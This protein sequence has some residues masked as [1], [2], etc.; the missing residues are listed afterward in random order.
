MDAPAIRDQQVHLLQQAFG[1]E[2][3]GG[4]RQM[5]DIAGIVITEPL[6]PV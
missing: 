1:I 6:Q 3:D 4:A 2:R 5:L